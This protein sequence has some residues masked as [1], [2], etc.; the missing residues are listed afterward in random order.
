MRVKVKSHVVLR[1]ARSARR[2]PATCGRRR[3]RARTRRRRRRAGARTRRRTR[4][5]RRPRLAVL[6]DAASS[7]SASTRSRSWLDGLEPSSRARSRAYNDWLFDFCKAHPKQMIG[8]GMVAP[9][10][11][12]A[13]SPEARR[14]TELGFRASSSRPA[15][16]AA[17]VARPALRSALGRVREARPRR[18]LPRRRAEPSEARLLARGLRPPDDVATFSQPLGIMA[19]GQHHRRRRVRALRSSASRLLEA[20]SWAPWLFY[21]STSITSGWPRSRRRI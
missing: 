17:T 11:V 19:R 10:D 12:P 8:A 14:A 15:P 16:S 3:R 1:S 18:R 2:G 21:P 9:H 7:C 13:P 20:P 4:W 6:F 5:I